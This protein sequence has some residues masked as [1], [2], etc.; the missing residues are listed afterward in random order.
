MIVLPPYGQWPHNHHVLF[1]ETTCIPPPRHKSGQLFEWHFL[2]NSRWCWTSRRTLATIHGE[3]GSSRIE[4]NPHAATWGAGPVQEVIPQVGEMLF[5]RAGSAHT[6]A[7]NKGAEDLRPRQRRLRED[8]AHRLPP[9]PTATTST[10]HLLTSR[11]G[12]DSAGSV[13]TGEE[14]DR[15]DTVILFWYGEGERARREKLYQTR[16]YNGVKKSLHS[17]GFK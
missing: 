15:V 3:L 17:S 5:R 4:E 16:G 6:T 9:S 13:T 12:R 14:R 1:V 10:L 11:S 8:G 2:Y 7:A